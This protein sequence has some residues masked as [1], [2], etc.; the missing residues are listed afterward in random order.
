MVH[1]SLLFNILG[2]TLLSILFVCLKI[3]CW[4]SWCSEGPLSR[5]MVTCLWRF[6]HCWLAPIITHPVPNVVAH[7][8]ARVDW[9]ATWSASIEQRPQSERTV[10]H[11]DPNIAAIVLIMQPKWRIQHSVSTKWLEWY[12]K[13][14][15]SLKVVWGIVWC[16]TL[17]GVW[18][19]CAFDKGGRSLGSEHTPSFI[20]KQGF[21]FITISRNIHGALLE[22]DSF[23]LY[24]L[25]KIVAIVDSL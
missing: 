25:K 8:A 15:N 18:L 16:L 6:E 17:C 4:H 11:C 7:R 13:V 22:R 3:N 2:H 1:R 14:W 24:F 5:S 9:R 23:N 19:H 12:C 10:Y 21:I 20:P